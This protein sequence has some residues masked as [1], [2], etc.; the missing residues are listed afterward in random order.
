MP[1]AGDSTGKAAAAGIATVMEIA[2]NRRAWG[3]YRGQMEAPLRR[4]IK[5]KILVNRNL[6]GRIWSLN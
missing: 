1:V 6:Q 4:I 5:Q 3:E 2:E